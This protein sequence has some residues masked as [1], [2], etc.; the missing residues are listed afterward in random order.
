M[1]LVKAFNLMLLLKLWITYQ[2]SWLDSSKREEL[3]LWLEWLKMLEERE[4]LK[5][6]V[7][8]KLSKFSE[9]EKMS[10]IKNLWVYIKDLLIHIFKM[11]SVRLLIVLH[12]SRH[13]A[14]LSSKHKL[15]TSSLIKLS[16][17]KINQ[18][19]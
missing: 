13:S 4:K 11:Y 2:K 19:F 10:F 1:E 17:R 12:H 7:E 5:N 3:Q 9:I 6:L 16:K 14:K 18:K 8:D 15:S